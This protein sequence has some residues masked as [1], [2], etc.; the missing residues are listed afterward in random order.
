MSLAL[1]GILLLQFYWI[2]NVHELHAEEFKTDVN[3]AVE[4]A[5]VDIEN[6]EKNIVYSKSKKY[7]NNLSI[8]PGVISN[9]L[10]LLE[11]FKIHDTIISRD[12]K[13]LQY[14]VVSGVTRDSVSGASAEHRVITQDF[15]LFTDIEFK[16]K[17]LKHNDSC[18]SMPSYLNQ[19]VEQGAIMKSKYLNE[20]MLRMFTSNIFDD[21]RV[22]LDPKVLDT[23]IHNRLLKED[24]DT[25]FQFRIKDSK[26]EVITFEDSPRR[27]MK[28]IDDPE[29]SFKLYPSDIVSTQYYLELDFP[30]YKAYMIKQM[31]GTLIASLFLILIIVFSF[32][33]A[34][35]TIFQ[36]KK[37]SEIKN[38]FISNMTHELKTPI[39]TI[40][41]ACEAIEDP[42]IKNNIETLN[43]FID[44]I[45]SENKR[46]GNLVEKVLQTSLLERGKLNLQMSNYNID[47]LVTSVIKSF[48]IQF[49]QRGGELQLKRLDNV[50]HEVDKI[51]FSNVLFNLMDNALKY[52]KDIP[53]TKVELIKENKGFSILIIDNG[54]GI[55][56]EDQKRIFDKLY[57]VSTG[58]VHDVKGF[59]LG[60][61]YVKKIIDMHNGKLTVKSE[62]NKGS[63]FKI[64]IKNE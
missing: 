4:M 34:V 15:S 10:N 24:L 40:S 43:S 46:L 29:F 7:K 51:H 5:I 6:F 42:D 8:K 45:A 31:F 21:I 52:S 14:L 27:Y 62:L 55:K 63:T 1:V 37:V 32:Y 18:I 38:D 59:G 53:I 23:L 2:R 26:H 30:N 35:Y 17:T 19:N 49:K 54:I 28:Q 33:F 64:T 9:Q 50:I 20:L 58:D 25:L 22:R 56:K 61:D 47:E 39:S 36:Q 57:R 12:N 60:L 16:S 41:L 11:S 44:M 48:E 3:T 13:K